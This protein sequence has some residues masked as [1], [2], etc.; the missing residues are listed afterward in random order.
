MLNPSLAN[1]GSPSKRVKAPNTPSRHFASR[2]LSTNHPSPAGT[3]P[4][5]V[6]SIGASGTMTRIISMVTLEGVSVASNGSEGVHA[7]EV[8]D[9]VK[10]YPKSPVN[11]VDGINFA[12]AP[13][14]VFRLLG[15]NG[16]GKTTTVGMLTT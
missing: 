15:P 7:V 4:A 9:L 16:A 12:V 13:G 11:A 14:Q 1:R 8:L 2:T 10:R 3:R 6:L 5:G